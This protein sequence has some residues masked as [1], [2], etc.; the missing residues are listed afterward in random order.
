MRDIFPR[1]YI[2]TA[3]W[4]GYTRRFDCICDIESA[5]IS[6]VMNLEGS[7][8]TVKTPGVLI[9]RNKCKVEINTKNIYL[10]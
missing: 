4:A 9:D 2:N 8:L 6:A 5:K 7:Q 1:K 3:L 10:T